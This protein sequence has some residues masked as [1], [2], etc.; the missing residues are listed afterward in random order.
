MHPALCTKLPHAGINEWITSSPFTPSCELFI[1]LDTGV[2]LHLGIKRIEVIRKCVRSL[3][4]N[5]GIE[6]TPCDFFSE[7]F[8]AFAI[9]QASQQCAGM[10]LAPLQSNT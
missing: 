5:F 8:M 3:E 1:G 2:V 9:A 7:N 4:S 10:D 6:L